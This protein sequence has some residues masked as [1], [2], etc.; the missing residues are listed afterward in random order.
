M[1]LI[2]AGGVGGSKFVKGASLVEEDVMAIINTGDDFERFG[3]YISPDID[4]N[5]YTLANLIHEQGWGFK[6]ETYSSQSVLSEIYGEDCWFNLGDKD[7]AT[8]IFR[9]HLMKENKTLTEITA[10]L[11]E[12]LGIKARVIPMS[13]E[14][15]QT[16]INTPEGVIHFQK[17][18]IKRN[19]SDQVLGIHLSGIEH[20]KP[21]P[22]MMDAI[23]SAKMIV[24]APSN[25]FVSIGPILAVPGIRNAIRE[26]KAVVAAIS[27]IIGGKAVKGPAAKMLADLQVEVS[28]IGIAKLY[29][30]LLD[31]MVIDRQDEQY[32]KQLE[33]HGFDVLVTN[34]ILD[35]DQRKANLAKEVIE[36][37]K[38][39][40]F[41]ERWA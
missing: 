41:R 25:P 5:L 21:A 18:L 38:A 13:N 26:S 15:V 34:T 16:Y 39:G 23:H 17:Y 20:A 7:L 32:R 11:C 33:H 1:V 35:S 36:F 27:P 24:L 9:T 37:I 2:L 4:I 30:D 12:R 40:S 28:P 8:H 29:E 6:D 14:P 10:I 22:G 31:V 3:L 19:M